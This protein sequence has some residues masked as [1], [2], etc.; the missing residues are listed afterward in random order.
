MPKRKKHDDDVKVPI[1]QLNGTYQEKEK[2]SKKRKQQQEEVNNEDSF[3]LLPLTE[4]DFRRVYIDS[5][6][7]TIIMTF[8][9]S[10]PQPKDGVVKFKYSKDDKSEIEGANEVNPKVKY[11]G[12]MYPLQSVNTDV[13]KEYGIKVQDDDG[14]VRIQSCRLFKMKPVVPDISK[15]K[16][17]QEFENCLEEGD[18]RFGSKIVRTQDNQRR[19]YEV[20]YE[21][22]VLEKVKVLQKDFVENKS[23]EPT[24]TDDPLLMPVVPPRDE[25]AKTVSTVYKLDDVIPVVHQELV[26]NLLKD[27]AA[28]EKEILCPL[29]LASFKGTKDARKKIICV[30]AGLL[31][32]M[33]KLKPKELSQWSP[34]TTH[35]ENATG[36]AIV[37]FFAKRSTLQMR[38]KD[39]ESWVISSQQK[40]AIIARLLIM[41]M[42]VEDYKSLGVKRLTAVLEIPVKTV[43]NVGQAIGCKPD[44]IKDSS[45]HLSD[46]LHFKIPLFKPQPRRIKSGR[47]RR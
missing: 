20:G 23:Q 42:M 43:L 11:V 18:K 25:E 16:R 46:I 47:G 19:K 30:Y 39:I 41:I 14:T 40:D 44:K 32:R 2:K 5:D 6:P 28:A 8:W 36:N 38:G 35:D 3:C 45:G 29:I 27:P 1:E 17:Q 37:Q 24:P 33:L 7:D 31:H 21:E 9:D 4:S 22:E 10:C 34:L 26:E 13:K 12:H 15:R